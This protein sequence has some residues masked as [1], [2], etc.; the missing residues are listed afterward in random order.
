MSVLQN[1]VPLV[2]T[3]PIRPESVTPPKATKPPLH[4]IR[5]SAK[6]K[7]VSTKANTS[8]K[9][10]EKVGKNKTLPKPGRKRNRQEIVTS[11]ASTSSSVEIMANSLDDTAPRSASSQQV[12][13]TVNAPQPNRQATSDALSLLTQVKYTFA[14]KPQIYQKFLVLLQQSKRGKITTPELSY[15]IQQLFYGYP[16]LLQLYNKFLPQKH[17]IFLQ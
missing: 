1:P 4:Q 7:R 9:S 12:P 5:R 13:N 3:A 16:E 2:S 17:K 14:D 11:Q 15:Q 10:A 6:P 8:E